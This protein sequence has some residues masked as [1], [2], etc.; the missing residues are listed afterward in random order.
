MHG[1]ALK[2]IVV[3]GPGRKLGRNSWQWVRSGPSCYTLD[4]L[5]ALEGKFL[6][7]GEKWAQPLYSD[8]FTPGFKGRTF[9]R[10]RFS[11]EGTF[12]SG[13]TVASVGSCAQYALRLVVHVKKKKVYIYV[14]FN[15]HLLIM[16][17]TGKELV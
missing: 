2:Q 11:A 4:L 1:C 5:Q 7:M 3:N 8:I 9:D 12:I 6:A 14:V 10:P 13:P 16:G 15:V 17:S